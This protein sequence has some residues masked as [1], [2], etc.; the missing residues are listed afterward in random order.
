[1]K[2]YDEW[3]VD[4]IL[5][6]LGGTIFHF[7]VG[8][9]IMWGN[10]TPY[11]TSYLVLFDPNVTY[12]N[13][14]H[15]YTGVFL[16][17]SLTMYV[18]GKLENKVGPRIS[19]YIGATIISGCT[20]LSSYCTTLRSLVVLQAFVGVG[21]GLSYSAALICGFNHFKNNKGLVTGVITTGAG[22]GPFLSGL[23]ATSYVNPNNI[24]VD[25]LT[26]LYSPSS[27]VVAR[28][29][30]M[31]KLLGIAYGI[32]GFVGASLLIPKFID[33]SNKD[34]TNEAISYIAPVDPLFVGSEEVDYEG[35][36]LTANNGG[37][38]FDLYDKTINGAE[39]RQSSETIKSILH[40][41]K[42][43]NRGHHQ[44]YGSRVKIEVRFELTTAQMISDSLCWLVIAT[45]I[46]TSVPGFYVA[47]TYKSFGLIYIEDDHFITVIGCLS[48][49]G[50]G[51]SR[52]LW[53]IIADKIGHFETLE[54]TAYAY[55]AVML[56]YSLM[57]MFS[58]WSG[59]ATKVAFGCSVCTMFI[60]WGSS[61]CLMPTIVSFLFGDKHLGTNY[62]FVFLVYGV[63]CVIII[64][65]A[66][67]SGYDF[68]FLNFFFIAVSF[69]GAALCSHLRYLTSKVKDEKIL[70]HHRSTSSV[71]SML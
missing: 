32:A 17:Q 34:D 58:F 4:A 12:Y 51:V 62:G 42:H 45:G 59:T 29:P 70:R 46:C 22:L 55:P 19:S 68:G 27:A 41:K 14:L 3:N 1:M 16:G 28:V 11:V 21:I 35:T 63:L 65:N 44:R 23:M 60:L 31:F 6:L 71:H 64:D 26:G 48:C 61:G 25:T 39:T 9:K 38:E 18:G 69:V 10:I 67:N 13:T 57:S 54:Y 43:G 66:G 33:K 50:L 52:P 40:H 49:L 47:A 5:S 53:G 2:I 8:V 24:P 37:V 56:V 7:I 36:P 30:G 15:V 20:Y